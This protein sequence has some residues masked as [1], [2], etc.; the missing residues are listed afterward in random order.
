MM[1]DKM[2]KALN[3]QI[4]AEMCSAYLYL[5]MSS[6]FSSINLDGM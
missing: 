5:A 1:T 6:Y 4:N 3:D 2:T